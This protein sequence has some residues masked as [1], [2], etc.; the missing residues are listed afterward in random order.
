MRAFKNFKPFKISFKLF[1]EQSFENFEDFEDILRSYKTIKMFR[2]LNGK[3]V[4]KFVGFSKAKK[5]GNYV[6][7]AIVHTLPYLF[8]IHLHIY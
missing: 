8:S 5:N 4:Q 3:L 6:E 2:R 1:I 7:G